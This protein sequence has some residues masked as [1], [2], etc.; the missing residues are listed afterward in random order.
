[1]RCVYDLEMKVKEQREVD[2]EIMRRTEVA[3]H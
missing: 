3:R 2:I 1:M